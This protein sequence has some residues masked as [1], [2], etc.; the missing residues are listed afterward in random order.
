MID[1]LDLASENDAEIPDAP[2]EAPALRLWDETAHPAIEARFHP[3]SF[4]AAVAAGEVTVAS[5]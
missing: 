4:S 1:P 5:R 2:D 3:K